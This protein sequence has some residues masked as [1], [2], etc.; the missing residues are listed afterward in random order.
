MN[1]RLL[2]RS[3]MAMLGVAA[4]AAIL[5]ACDDRPDSAGEAIENAGDKIED[6]ADDVGDKI[7]DAADDVEDAVDDAVD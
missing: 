6:A 1:S 4:S 7:D 3:L 2:T 5:P